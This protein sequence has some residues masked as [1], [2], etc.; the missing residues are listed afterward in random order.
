M[1]E[2]DYS[3][4]EMAELDL[5]SLEPESIPPGHK[6]GFVAVI[7]RPN[8]G[9][10]TL[11]NAF[12]RQKI[13]IVTPR[14]QTTRSNQL[15]IVT[16]Q[17]YQ[18][19]FVDTPG[20]ISPRHKLDEYMVS[21]ANESLKDADVLL[22]LVDAGEP[23]GPGDRFIAESLRDLSDDPAMILAINKS[24]LVSPEQVIHR[25]G[26]YRELLPNASWLLIS[27]VNGDGLET[28]L[29]MIVAALPEGPRYFPADQ[30]TDAYMRDIAA[31]LIREQIFLQMRE[32]LPYGSAVLVDEFIERDNGMTY[33][34]ATIYVERES[35]KKI[36]VGAKG[37]Q[38]RRIGSA[39][40]KGIEEL[41]EGKAYLDLWVKVEPHWRRN[42]QSLKRLGY[43][44]DRLPGS[45]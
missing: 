27:A 41:I 18:I 35:H 45:S 7:G 34:K 3:K 23:P 33:I 32:E 24:D 4:S 17:V 15:G 37:R 29:N 19:I 12:L 38:L 36:I 31:E 1:E 21:A 28:L 30:T 16:R 42:E 20:I 44:T 11:M 14:P 40:R 25:T 43:S 9:K 13:A 26:E 5:S 6:S 22:W 39:A 8:V 2:F 10:S